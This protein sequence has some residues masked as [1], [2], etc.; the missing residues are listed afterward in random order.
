MGSISVVLSFFLWLSGVNVVQD[1]EACSY[2]PN[3]QGEY[4]LDSKTI[5][6]CNDNIKAKNRFDVNHTI[7]HEMVHAIHH[8]L[9]MEKGT[10]IPE[11][12]LTWLVRGMMD[13]KETM[14]V[15]LYY[16]GETDQ[17]FEARILAYVPDIII[18]PSLYLSS[19]WKT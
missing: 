14:S 13:D 17:E 9:G 12:Q 19:L 1:R 11:P 10:F 6:V 8:N 16:P 15:L 18:G 5:G 2:E 4:I 7:R 3:L